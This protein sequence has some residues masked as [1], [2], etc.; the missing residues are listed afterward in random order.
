M[1]AARPFLDHAVVIP[2]HAQRVVDAHD[3]AV[4]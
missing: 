2:P 3:R 4:S 1:I